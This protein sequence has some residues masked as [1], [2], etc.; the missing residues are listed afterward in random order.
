MGTPPQI[1]NNVRILGNLDSG[2]SI[3][4]VHG[5]G[6]DQTSWNS[7]IPAFAEDHRI[8]VFDNVGAGES[9]PEAF[10]QYKYLG[11][12]SYTRDL[13][14]ICEALEIRD[15]C[16]I[17]HSAGGMIGAL[18]TIAGK[19]HFSKLVLLGASPRYL[20]DA[21]Y[22][23]GFTENDLKTIYSTV[24]E[25]FLG[26]VDDFAPKAM[27]HPDKPELSQHFADTIRRIKPENVLTVLCAI[28][29]SDHREDIQD[30]D[31]PTLIIQAR[32]DL[33][34]PM[35]VALYLRDNIRD[36]RLVSIQACGHFPH[37]SAPQEVVR[38]IRGF[39]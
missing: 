32:E 6:T 2:K 3:I 11:L 35:E 20:D 21:Q 4:L 15:A 28:L 37:M 13:L 27:N 26:W 19:Q 30:I 34:V 8:I 9:D 22:V 36:S 24:V 33:F 10:V 16:V 39:L 12:K 25:N 18:A 29:Q 5:F 14:D 38:A 31:V 7:M 17:G 1:K 23:G